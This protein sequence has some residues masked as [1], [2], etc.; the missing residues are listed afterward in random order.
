M[1]QMS[2]K[3]PLSIRIV[4]VLGVITLLGVMYDQSKY[5][6][7]INYG[8]LVPFVLLV[9]A[10]FGVWKARVMVHNYVVDPIENKIEAR[11]A[12]QDRVY[13]DLPE[14]GKARIDKRTA[15][16]RVVTSAGK[17]TGFTVLAFLFNPI[18]GCIIGAN[19]IGKVHKAWGNYNDESNAAKERRAKALR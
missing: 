2:Y 15:E 8:M 17:W 10:M 19:A 11:R 14:L 12:E 16:A 13:A 4:S 6:D 1:A 3:Y 5:D 9:A 7:S 18:A